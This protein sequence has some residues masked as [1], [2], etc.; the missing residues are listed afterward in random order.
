MR[1][2]P[3]VVMH[4]T[5][6]SDSGQEHRAT[7][8]A[9]TDCKCSFTPR[10]CHADRIRGLQSASDRPSGIRIDG[11]HSAPEVEMLL[12]G[13]RVD[14]CAGWIAAMV[15]VGAALG[16]D[17]P[18]PPRVESAAEVARAPRPVELRDPQ[19]FAAAIGAVAGDFDYR[20]DYH[21]NE[22]WFT[23]NI[24]LWAGLLQPYMG[25]PGIQYL[26]VGLWEG[27]SF[28]WMLDH[29]LTD[30]D[31]HATGV[32]IEVL[33][34]LLQN[35]ELSGAADRV[36]MLEGSSQIVLRTL[37]PESQDLIY[38]DGSH[39]SADVLEDMVLSWRLLKP[40]GLMILDDYRWNGSR[41]AADP[42]LS[43]DLLP[44]VAI[45]AFISANRNVVVVV[46]KGYQVALR[47]RAL[48]C[49]RGIYQ[50][51]SLGPYSYDWRERKLH[52]GG[53][54]V[55]LSDAERDLVEV[56][57]R[58]KRGDA[59]TIELA[60]EYAESAQLRGLDRRLELGLWQ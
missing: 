24:P 56:L 10:L 22:D 49:P 55:A 40:G 7:S 57:I 33:D 54:N 60:P 30:S 28:V 45:D 6:D 43:D 1:F 13:M 23:H 58:S 2:I 21:F 19:A 34:N 9:F 48:E 41:N 16:C 44:R 31:S 35:I 36:T 50:C 27:R 39:I 25:M 12:N 42:P 59:L 14:A 11:L 46:L 37:P 3:F 17:E 26:E 8:S 32:D 29:V 38:I 20:R 15:L 18:G 52:R 51:S 47:K 5:D 4:A 53:K